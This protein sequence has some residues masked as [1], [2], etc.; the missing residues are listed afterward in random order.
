MNELREFSVSIS[1]GLNVFCVASVVC[2]HM[3]EPVCQGEDSVSR[4][5]SVEHSVKRTAQSAAHAVTQVTYILRYSTWSS[6]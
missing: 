4:T 6:Q 1:N 2:L 5:T 3:T